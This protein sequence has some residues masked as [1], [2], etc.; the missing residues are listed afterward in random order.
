MKEGLLLLDVFILFCVETASLSVTDGRM[1]IRKEKGK[2]S[3][4]EE[5]ATF[6]SLTASSFMDKLGG[7]KKNS[8]WKEEMKQQQQ[9]ELLLAIISPESFPRRRDGLTGMGRR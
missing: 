9:P 2:A 5:E 1:K 8:R 7:R 3:R 6:I 4:A